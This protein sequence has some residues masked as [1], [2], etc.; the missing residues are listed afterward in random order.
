MPLPAALQ[1]RLQRRGLVQK[2][3]DPPPQQPD[4]EHLHD[5]ENIALPI[6]KNYKLVPLPPGWFKVPDLNTNADYYWNVHTNQVSWRHPND[7]R[8]EL[9]YPACWLNKSNERGEEKKDDKSK[10][11]NK[12]TG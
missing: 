11:K 6:K 8:A 7:P 2:E 4:N 3:P 1:A 10:P 5:N 9:T 12:N